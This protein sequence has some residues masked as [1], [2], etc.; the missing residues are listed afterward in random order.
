VRPSLPAGLLVRLTPTPTLTL[1]LTVT[2]T[3]T[4]VWTPTLNT[5]HTHADTL[6]LHVQRTRRGDQGTVLPLADTA[7]R[8]HAA[9]CICCTS[10]AIS[11]WRRQQ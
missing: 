7:A 11:T 10:L 4:L 1:A 8:I 6:N 2:L 9:V 3:L 5:N